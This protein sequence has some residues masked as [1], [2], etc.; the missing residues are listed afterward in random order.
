MH[1]T[2]TVVVVGE[3]E[4][5]TLSELM[6]FW[7]GANRVPPGGFGQRMKVDFYSLDEVGPG[8]LPSSSTCSLTLWLPRGIED[9]YTMME[10]LK[11]ACQLSAGFGKL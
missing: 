10:L 9:P 1:H 2:F 7:T 8:R 3:S 4:D 11:D 6:T 5:I